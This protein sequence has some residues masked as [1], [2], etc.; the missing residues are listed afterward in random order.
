MSD[1][2]KTT[3]FAVK[4]GLASG[5]PAKVVKG[6]EIDVE[7]NNIQIANNTKMDSTNP[8]FS[9]TMT[10]FELTLTGEMEAA[11]VDGGTY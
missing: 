5:N 2:T 3:D 6:T 8:N 7:F 4:D 11:L 9:G 10:G 1:Y